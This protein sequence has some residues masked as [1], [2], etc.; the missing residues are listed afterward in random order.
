MHYQTV[1]YLEQGVVRPSLT[2]PYASHGS[3]TYPSRSPSRWSRSLGWAGGPAHKAAWARRLISVL[4]PARSASMGAPST[5][6]VGSGV[7]SH[8]MISSSFIPP[9][10]STVNVPLS[11]GLG[12]DSMRNLDGIATTCALPDAGGEHLAIGKVLADPG[13]GHAQAFGRIGN[14]EPLADQLL[15]IERLL[16]QVRC[17]VVGVCD[18]ALCS[19]TRPSLPPANRAFARC[20]RL[21]CWLPFSPARSRSTLMS[22]SLTSQRM[23]YCHMCHI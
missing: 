14:G 15:E 2:W 7:N 23:R 1:G 12:P 8:A 3:S 6:S 20:R 13:Q 10:A 16:G 22:F 5:G 17:G 4:C 21:I 9:S 11:S 19:V 18:A